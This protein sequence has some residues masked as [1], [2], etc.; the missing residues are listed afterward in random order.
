M[1][2]YNHFYNKNLK[3]FARENRKKQT[4]GEQKLWKYLKTKQLLGVRFLR[5]RSIDK[6]IVDFFAPEYNLAIEVDGSSHDESKYEYDVARQ[7]VLEKLNI[8]V[9]RFTEVE[10]LRSL[11]LVLQT[12]ENVLTS[13]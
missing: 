12:I 9:V 7:K 2:S 10:V 13:F 6:Y 5:Q 8:M 1:K 3:K 11:N 4:P